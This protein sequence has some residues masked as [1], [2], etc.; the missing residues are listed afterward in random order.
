MRKI[1]ITS[2]AV[3]A[4]L[5]AGGAIVA[6]ATTADASKASYSSQFQT[7]HVI[8]HAVTDTTADTGP[9]GDSLGD[10]LAFRN[11]IFGQA[12]KNRIGTDNGSCI[13]TKK[14][15]AY[16]CEWTLTLP[17]GQLMVQGP[18]FDTSDSQLTITGGTGAFLGATGQMRL[19]ARNAKGSAYDFVY[20]V[21]K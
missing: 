11:P 3:S 12:N 17:K 20:H 4:V 13:R 14:G 2:I 5:V 15:A 9:K 18:F 19:H 6:E 1:V 10:V 16:E 21:K 8:E 7:L